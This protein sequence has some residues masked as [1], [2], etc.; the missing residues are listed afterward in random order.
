MTRHERR[1][2]GHRVG[3]VR[4][5]IFRHTRNGSSSVTTK[6]VHSGVDE[7]LAR[8]RLEELS[9]ELAKVVLMGGVDVRGEA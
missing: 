1:A 8:E 7:Q 9:R 2:N 4:F 3:K 5:R 6:L